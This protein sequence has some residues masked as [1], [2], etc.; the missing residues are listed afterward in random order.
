MDA[1]AHTLM[2][3]LI[4][5]SKKKNNSGKEQ[6]KPKKKNHRQ[7]HITKYFNAFYKFISASAVNE[8]LREPGS[9]FRVVTLMIIRGSLFSWQLC[10]GEMDYACF[11]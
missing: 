4:T 3:Y 7:P 6:K 9:H 10:V 8:G 5:L 2:S 1:D 11:L